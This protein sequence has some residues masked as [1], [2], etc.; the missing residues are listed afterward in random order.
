MTLHGSLAKYRA[1]LERLD[2]WFC[3]LRTEYGHQIQCGKGCSRCCYGLFDISLPDAWQISESLGELP[4][5]MR[6]SITGRAS[7]IQE[8]IRRECPEIPE[9][10]FLHMISPDKVDHIVERIQDARCPLLDEN[11][12]C[13][14]YHHRP[15]ACRLEGIPMVDAHDGLFEDWCTLN[16]KDGITPERMEDLRLDYYEIQAVER[17]A[18]RYLALEFLGVRQEEITLFIPSVVVGLRWRQKKTSS[19]HKQNARPQGTAC[20]P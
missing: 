16:F 3:N 19:R 20:S 1:L 9:P 8:R 7:I 18:S 17:K 4:E 2:E 15:L 5:T 10:F 12:E 13:L 6:S 14:L 11:D